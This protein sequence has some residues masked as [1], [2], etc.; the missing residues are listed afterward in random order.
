MADLFSKAI[1]FEIP[2]QDIEVL[3]RAVGNHALL[4]LLR[5]ARRQKGLVPIVELGTR[6]GKDHEAL[7]VVVTLF[8]DANLPMGEI[9]F[10]VPKDAGD[11]ETTRE[12]LKFYGQ[13]DWVDELIL[14]WEQHGTFPGDRTAWITLLS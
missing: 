13:P 1:L 11:D 12:V 10:A 5:W 3:D 8:E 2:A 14:R 6:M 7:R 9:E 4:E